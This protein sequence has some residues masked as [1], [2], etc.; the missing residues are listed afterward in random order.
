MSCEKSNKRESSNS[1]NTNI[2]NSNNFGNS[3]NTPV[4]NSTT[5]NNEKENLGS[6]SQIQNSPDDNLELPSYEEVLNFQ[7]YSEENSENLS[8]RSSQYAP[9]KNQ[10]DSFVDHQ[11]SQIYPAQQIPQSQPLQQKAPGTQQQQ[12]SPYLLNNTSN[13]TSFLQIQPSKS[14]TSTTSTSSFLIGQ[15]V[16]TSSNTSQPINPLNSANNDS[17]TQSSK[18]VE[19]NN[20]SY[21]IKP[22]QPVPQNSYFQ[23]Q[24]GQPVTQESASNQNFETCYDGE[25][26]DMNDTITIS[27]GTFGT[28]KIQVKALARVNM[29]KSTIGN[30]IIDIRGARLLNGES[31]IIFDGTLGRLILVVPK[32]LSL[33]I[34]DQYCIGE[35]LS[36]RPTEVPVNEAKKKGLPIV[37]VMVKNTLGDVNIIEKGVN[38]SVSTESLN[39]EIKKLR[40]EYIKNNKKLGKKKTKN[41]NM[42]NSNGNNYGTSLISMKAMF[43]KTF[44]SAKQQI[45]N[46]VNKPVNLTPY[47]PAA[48]STSYS[49]TTTAPYG[50]PTQSSSTC[51]TSVY[52]YS[53]QLNYSYS[54]QGYPLQ[55]T[56]GDYPLTFQQVTTTAPYSSLPSAPIST[57]S[58]SSTGSISVGHA[59]SQNYITNPLI[60]STAPPSSVIVTSS[61]GS[62]PNGNVNINASPSYSIVHPCIN[63]SN[64]ISATAP[65]IIF[66]SASETPTT[67]AKVPYPPRA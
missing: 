27:T 7:L 65:P 42:E 18:P 46:Q 16:S 64:S 26:Q 5:N 61:I 24:Q 11:S 56:Q 52:P 47:H 21:Q 67:N 32:Y 45:N 12:D 49:Y 19:T 9:N 10:Y 17:T 63:T 59:S 50:V 41:N 43:K 33:I 35:V 6:T 57:T 40:K 34:E 13:N 23:V 51:S 3:N 22:G 31:Q 20:I 30:N 48:Q 4:S 60:V 58:L 8:P 66:S 62:Q 15:P 2:N 53:S 29:V 25:Y 55:A 38:I 39:L 44:N 37:R 28:R 54:Y 36:H 14:I 1:E